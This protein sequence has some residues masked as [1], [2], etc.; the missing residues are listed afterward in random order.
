MFRLACQENKEGSNWYVWYSSKQYSNR[1]GPF[2][3][4]VFG[5]PVIGDVDGDGQGDLIMV[6]GSQ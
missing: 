6:D 5:T 1:Y 4:G 2:D 3:R